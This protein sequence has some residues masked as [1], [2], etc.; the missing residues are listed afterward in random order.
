MTFKIGDRIAYSVQFLRSIGEIT[1]EMP[2]ARGKITGLKELS[3]ECVL[4]VIEWENGDFPEKVNTKN[5]AKVGLNARF[6]QC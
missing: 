2:F 1:G 3:K 6:S 5:L 4:A